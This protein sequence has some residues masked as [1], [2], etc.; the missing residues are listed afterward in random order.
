MISMAIGSGIDYL[1]ENINRDSAQK[2]LE[3]LKEMQIELFRSDDKEM[4]EIGI[5][6]ISIIESV[7]KGLNV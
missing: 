5:R 6:L 1:V 4:R 7:T 2:S 3:S